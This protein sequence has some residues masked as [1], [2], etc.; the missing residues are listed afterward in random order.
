MKT[1]SERDKLI[2]QYSNQRAEFSFC[3]TTEGIP[4]F[5]LKDNSVV[6]NS[7]GSVTWHVKVIAFKGH[8]HAFIQL[9]TGRRKAKRT[10]YL[11]IC[12]VNPESRQIGEALLSAANRP[13]SKAM[14]AV[15]VTPDGRSLRVRLCIRNLVDSLLGF[16]MEK[17]FKK[18]VSQ[19]K[20]EH[21]PLCRILSDAKE[22]TP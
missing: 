19:F 6:A 20:S 4:C 10:V 15:F 3:L 1:I 9:T 17:Y 11:P 2:R 14:K 7:D 5:V 16:L 18:D 21:C 13:R 12:F 22:R 8:G